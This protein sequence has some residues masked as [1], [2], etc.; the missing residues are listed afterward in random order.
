MKSASEKV[1]ELALEWHRIGRDVGVGKANPSDYHN[2][3]YKLWDGI[4]ELEKELE[5]D[6]NQ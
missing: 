5:Q 4:E 3:L 1:L 6:N 2:A